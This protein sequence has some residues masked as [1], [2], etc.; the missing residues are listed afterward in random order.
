[1]KTDEIIERFK[2]LLATTADKDE[3][4]DMHE[5][6]Y[7]V[8]VKQAEELIS[9]LPQHMAEML[10]VISARYESHNWY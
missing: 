3:M 1:M 2:A 4:D 6:D 7:C 5:D 8:I 9:N 10:V